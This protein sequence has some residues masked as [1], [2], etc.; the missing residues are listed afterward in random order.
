MRPASPGGR[1]T[2]G[3][4]PRDGLSG[5]IPAAV[6]RGAV[7]PSP[8]AGQGAHNTGKEFESLIRHVLTIAL[9]DSPRSR[10]RATAHACPIDR[11]IV[12]WDLS[13]CDEIFGPKVLLMV[14][15]LD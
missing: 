5:I 13:R 3:P 12:A 8:L 10:Y 1:R 9:K 15:I 6:G 4:F 14:S 2:I 11:L 7:R